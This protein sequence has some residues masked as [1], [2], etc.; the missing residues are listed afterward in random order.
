MSDERLDPHDWEVR[1]AAG[2]QLD[3]HGYGIWISRYSRST[4]RRQVLGST[5]WK[6]VG[7]G[8]Y[9]SPTAFL[10][11]T[12]GAQ[13]LMT[14][15]WAA[16]ARPRHWGHEGEVAGLKNHLADMRQIVSAQLGINL[17]D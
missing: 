9:S 15:L 6:E 14:M 12:E 7:R 16:G 10:P 5:G 8:E 3:P 13:E 17:V 11:T 4:D 2:S 1:V